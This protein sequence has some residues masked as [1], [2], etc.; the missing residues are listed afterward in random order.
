MYVEFGATRACFVTK[1]GQ[2]SINR[3]NR[4]LEHRNR[5]GNFNGF[6]M[7]GPTVLH[8]GI[9]TPSLIRISQASFDMIGSQAFY[10]VL[11]RPFFENRPLVWRCRE[12]VYYNTSGKFFFF[13][14]GF[15]VRY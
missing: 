2:E 6:F 4:N 14:G 13:G 1:Q 7:K 10:M 15:F 9:I 12:F 11:E 3:K 5:R 8:L